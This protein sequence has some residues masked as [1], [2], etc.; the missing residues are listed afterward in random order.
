MT[1]PQIVAK[2]HSYYLEGPAHRMAQGSPP[3]QP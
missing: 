3:V 2:V 1:D